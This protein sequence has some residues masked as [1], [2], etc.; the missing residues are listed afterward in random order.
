MDIGLRLFASRSKT[1]WRFAERNFP[2]CAAH[3]SAAVAVHR[4]I[5]RLCGRGIPSIELQMLVRE[6]LPPP[7]RLPQMTAPIEYSE[8]PLDRM[9]MGVAIESEY[10]SMTERETLELLNAI[11]RT[12]YV[13][14]RLLGRSAHDC[15][16]LPTT[17][18]SRSIRSIVELRVRHSGGC[19]CT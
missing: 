9:E 10:R 7:A 14:E 12:E 8:T 3:R 17:I 18:W 11:T 19:T 2:R 4:G 16:W 5:E 15:T 13:F 6:I 1:A